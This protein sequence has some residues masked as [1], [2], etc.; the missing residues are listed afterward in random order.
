MI[1]PFY[2]APKINLVFANWFSFTV[3]LLLLAGLIAWISYVA[4]SISF[5][6]RQL[7]QLVTKAEAKQMLED[8]KREISGHAP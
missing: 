8:F 1:F 3:I 5:I 4:R 7:P 2:E 6:K